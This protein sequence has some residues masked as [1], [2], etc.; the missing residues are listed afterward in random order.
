[1]SNIETLMANLLDKNN[2]IRYSKSFFK[3]RLF[4]FFTR[5]PER[6]KFENGFYGTLGAISRLTRGLEPLYEIENS[7]ISEDKLNLSYNPPE[8]KSEIVD[9][10]ISSQSIESINHPFFINYLPVSKENDKSGEVEIAKLIVK[11]VDLDTNTLW[12]ELVANKTPTNLFE[13]VL[14]DAL[15]E[16]KEKDLKND[17]LIVN[18]ENYSYFIEDLNFLT[19]KK[20]FLMKN[21][22]N[23]FGFLYFQYIIQTSIYISNFEKVDSGFTQLYY[24]LESEKIS[25]SRPSAKRS[26]NIV[27]SL[28]KI[29]L[30]ND[31]LIGYIN[32]LIDSDDTYTIQEI[33]N[34]QDTNLKADLVKFMLLYSRKTDRNDISNIQLSENSL[35]TNINLFKSW[36]ESDI[37]EEPKARFFKSIDETSKLHFLKA[38]GRI[39]RVLN[40]NTDTILLLTAIIVKNQKMILSDLFIAFEKRGVWFDKITKEEIVK[41]YERMNLLDKKSDSGEAKYV[42][43]IL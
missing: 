34:M 33:L 10:L 7:P 36:L 18:K 39:G 9:E 22:H 21:I 19:E 15:T 4:P 43:P 37:Q 26:F 20:D 27:A 32:A 30:V 11:L 41:L 1:M 29:L 23:L 25:A 14:L 24:T 3:H 8:L 28:R 13:E 2:K 35:K 17:Y 38:R 40:L 16:L 42:K 5:N 12:N 6:A 31:Y